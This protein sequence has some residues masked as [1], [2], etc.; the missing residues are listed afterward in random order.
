MLVAVRGRNSIVVEHANA[1][2]APQVNAARHELAQQSIT[3]SLSSRP[4]CTPTQ[5]HRL[6]SLTFHWTP[7]QSLSL[8]FTTSQFLRNE[9]KNS[10]NPDRLNGRKLASLNTKQMKIKWL[11]YA[12]VPENRVKTWSRGAQ[13]NSNAFALTTWVS[14]SRYTV[15]R[16]APTN[17]KCAYYRT[18]SEPSLAHL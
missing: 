15:L 16:T 3:E 18:W 7:F 12:E 11:Q 6:N 14:S 4:E 10:A 8:A 5:L 13:V 9:T 17:V 1:S 2:Y